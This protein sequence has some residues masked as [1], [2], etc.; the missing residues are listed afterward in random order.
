MVLCQYEPNKLKLEI[1]SAMLT[2]ISSITNWLHLPPESNEGDSWQ[3]RGLVKASHIISEEMEL[4]LK[5]V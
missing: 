2:K 1:V 4:L 5:E 3:G